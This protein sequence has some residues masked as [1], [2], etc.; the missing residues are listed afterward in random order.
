[1]SRQGSITEE[2]RIKTQLRWTLSTWIRLS[3]SVTGL[4]IASIFKTQYSLGVGWSFPVN[5]IPCPHKKHNYMETQFNIHVISSKKMCS[6]DR[7]AQGP[8][9]GSGLVSVTQIAWRS[10]GLLATSSGPGCESLGE[11]LAVRVI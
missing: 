2:M 4:F 6:G 7:L 8:K 10:F 3:E 5:T 9:E 11:P 1:M